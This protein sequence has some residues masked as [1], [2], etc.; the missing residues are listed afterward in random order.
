MEVDRPSAEEDGCRRNKKQRLEI[1]QTAESIME[2]FPLK[3]LTLNV[4]K[5]FSEPL[6]GVKVNVD[7]KASSQDKPGLDRIG[8][9]IFGREII[10]AKFRDAGVSVLA[11]FGR[12]KSSKTGRDEGSVLGGNL[13]VLDCNQERDDG[14]TSLVE[15]AVMG[16]NLNRIDCIE[17]QIGG[18]SKKDG[19][20]LGS[21][22]FRKI[23][24]SS[25]S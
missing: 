2:V 21:M 4:Q 24:Y 25:N 5:V 9:H 14:G 8:S 12:D 18:E 13:N 17:G 6:N 11:E 3:T 7:L 15:D 16:G 23:S 20:M 1:Q 10:I 19:V 22:I